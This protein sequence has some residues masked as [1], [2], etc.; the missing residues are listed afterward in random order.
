[1]T[2]RESA[3]EL[4][5][6]KSDGAYVA[7]VPYVAGSSSDCFSTSL[8][9]VL[10]ELE[11]I[12]LLL[13]MW[14]GRIGQRLLGVAV[15]G[16]VIGEQE[17][18]DLI[19]RPLGSSPLLEPPGPASSD[20]SANRVIQWNATVGSRKEKSLRRGI[21]LRLHELQVSFGL[22]RFDVHC[23]LICLISELDVR[24]ERLYAY[25]QDDVT[26]K[27]P[28][29]DLVL[30]LLCSSFTE[31]LLRMDR[32]NPTAPLIARQL[33][34]LS[35]DPSQPP[36]SLLGR[37]LRL[38]ESI[39]RYLLDSDEI[40]SRISDYVSR[41][42]TQTS[43]EHLVLPD[44][45]MRKVVFLTQQPS[46]PKATVLYMQGPYGS[47]RKATAEALCRAWGVGCLLLDLEALISN[48]P[49]APAPALDLVLREAVL[50]Q[51]ALYIS[52]YES[53]LSDDK[54]PLKK[55]LWKNLRQHS[56]TVFLAGESAW[57]PR[58]EAAGLTV[59]YLELFLPDYHDRCALW[60]RVLEEGQRSCVDVPT[61]ANKFRFTG[62]QIRDAALIAKRHARS[63]VP[64]GSEIGTSDVIEAC[65]L[66]SSSKLSKLGRKIKPRQKWQDI[67]LPADRIEQLRE[68]CNAMQHRSRVLEEWGFD[69]KLSL[70]KGVNVLFAGPSGTGK[71]MAAEIMAGE[72]ELDL[73]KIDL[74]TVVSKY[75]GETEKNLARVF[76]EAECSNAILFFDEADALFG[77]RSEVRDSHDRYANIEINYL[78]QK[79]EEH[80]GVVVLATN[81][82]RNM[83]DA[84][85]RRMHFTVEFPLPS[86]ADRRRI[87]QQILP[88]DTPQADDLDFEFMARRFEIPGGNIRNVAMTAAFLAASDGG[89]V[90][91]N[92]LLHGTRRE[93]QK[94]GK[95]VMQGEFQ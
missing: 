31:K 2:I 17:V 88:K 62:G 60:T 93:Y 24:Y 70:G 52:G 3:A 49:A 50:R 4:D 55:T 81:F 77:K 59:L 42:R 9:H 75:I 89:V 58:E 51:D 6:L 5:T 39:V 29:I 95:V 34:L 45:I 78:L 15:D 30:N 10:A 36:N 44:D 48:P 13:Q 26:R 74:S 83:D 7:T 80:E 86:E 92:H 16:L 23:L 69:R 37:N 90:N 87:W 79:M 19:A 35:D 73:Y 65:R 53:L 61:L 76:A 25:L 8:D 32:F 1:M 67:V 28:T 94:M 20:A 11:G 66:Q 27:R 46:A 57:Q 68:I 91:M 63:R 43:L 12:R 82:R 84:F 72:L 56:G 54:L 64:D 33:L 22:T 41:L 71:T 21:K 18:G 40:D 47:G 14:V 85:I 38:D